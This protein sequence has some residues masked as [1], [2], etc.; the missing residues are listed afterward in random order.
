MG[1]LNIDVSDPVKDGN[2]NS[3]DFI[4]T[5]SLSSLI[6]RKTCRKNVSG[7][8]TDI[9]LTNKP[10]CFQKTSTVVTGPCD[11]H[12]MII[13]CLKT[14]FKKIPPKKIIFRDYK[15]LDKQNFLH[16]LNQQMIE[17]K[18]YKDKNMYENFSDTF[19]AVLNKHAP[20]KEK[21]LRG[22]NAPFMMKDLR[23]AIMNRSRLKKKYQDWPSR[24]NFKNWKKQKNKCNKLCRKLKRTILRISQTAV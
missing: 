23:K 16:D 9:M 1:D 6:N 3:S 22:N 2:N 7:T 11:F 10:H 19:K 14:A 5:F 12:E 15:K 17:K 13:S 20:V 18:F 24:E 4:D 21:L 8:T